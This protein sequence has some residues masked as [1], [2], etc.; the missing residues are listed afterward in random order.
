MNVIKSKSNIISLQIIFR[1]RHKIYINHTFETLHSENMTEKEETGFIG[2][3]RR[4]SRRLSGSILSADARDVKAY[5]NR[6][7]NKK[8]IFSFDKDDLMRIGNEY[9][10]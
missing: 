2:Q 3:I 4:L 10:F 1:C 8:N 6:N 9:E 7:D 5:L